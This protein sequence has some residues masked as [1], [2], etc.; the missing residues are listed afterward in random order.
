MTYCTKCGTKNEDDAKVCMKCGGPLDLSR[1]ER[2][3]RSDRDC[4]GP[5]EGRHKEDECFGLPHGGAI[6]GIIF[7][8][9]VVI[10]GL[11]ILLGFE[12]WTYLW[13]IIIVIV[14]ILI[15]VGALYGMRRRF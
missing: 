10:F 13:P 11:A 1:P 8:I 3:R 4:F 5:R 9:I 15:V 2:R 14:G 6:A 7:G 12:I